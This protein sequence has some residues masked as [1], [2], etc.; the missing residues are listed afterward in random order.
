MRERVRVCLCDFK[1]IFVVAIVALRL[2]PA[3]KAFQALEMGCYKRSLII[4]AIPSGAGI[5][6]WLE[7]RTRD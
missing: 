6:Q 7:H 3:L 1:C 5:A 2:N 4:I